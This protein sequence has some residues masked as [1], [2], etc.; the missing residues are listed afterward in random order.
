MSTPKF[1]YLCSY[2]F[3]VF[4]KKY[5]STKQKLQNYVLVTSCR[6]VFDGKTIHVWIFIYKIIFS[7]DF[8]IASNIEQHVIFIVAWLSHNSKIVKLYRQKLHKT[9]FQNSFKKQLYFVIL[10]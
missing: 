7:N 2:Q 8:K 3:H 10:K 1:Q 4:G 6:A 5:N 9:F